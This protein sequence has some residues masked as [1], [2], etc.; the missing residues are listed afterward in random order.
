[1]YN[2]LFFSFILQ[3]F[4]K[5]PAP[6]DEIETQGVVPKRLKL[7]KNTEIK[8]DDF[9]IV[10]ACFTLLKFTPEFFRYKWNWS[11]FIKKYF[12]H[13]ENTVKWLA[14]QCIAIVLGM[15]EASLNTLLHTKMTEHISNKCA[16]EY[17]LKF[18]QP[19]ET[20]FQV[21]TD[22]QQQI[23]TITQTDKILCISGICLPIYD[24]KN[25]RDTNIVTVES[26]KNN[27]R[28]IALGLASNQ[29]ICLIGPVGSGK[30]SLVD[31][32]ASRT[33]RLLGDKFIKLQLGDQ[34]DSKML[35]GTYRCT[36]IPGEFVW[37]PGVLT[38]VSFADS[39]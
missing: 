22:E 11:Y 19:I 23:K 36:D 26:T 39:F 32:L 28:Q 13:Q 34:T 25:I 3:Y 17:E 10:N 24:A 15:N 35:L 29:A 27:L 6:F 9:D 20:L 12:D 30:T 38:Q 2:C 31:Y 14:C 4:N 37:Q 1:M 7:Q 5:F 16:V 18:S 8:I 21:E 33:G